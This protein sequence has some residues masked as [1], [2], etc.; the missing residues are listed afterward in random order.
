[1]FQNLEDA[2]LHSNGTPSSQVTLVFLAVFALLSGN[3]IPTTDIV[4]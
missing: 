1:M 4:D 3:S 2:S